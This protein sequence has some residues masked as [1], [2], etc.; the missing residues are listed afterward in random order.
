[1]YYTTK[2]YENNINLCK[3]AMYKL[4]ENIANTE[5][6]ELKTSLIQPTKILLICAMTLMSTLM[7]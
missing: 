7:I 6:K 5:F 2:D 4:A 3:R 1:M